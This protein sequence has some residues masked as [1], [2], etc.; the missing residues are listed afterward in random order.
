MSFDPSC[1][2]F[3]ASVDPVSGGRNREL[4]GIRRAEILAAIRRLLVRFEYD[5][6]TVRR[7]AEASGYSVQTLYNLVGPRDQAV[8]DAISQYLSM[9]GQSAIDRA[10][11][12]FAL[13]TFV[14]GLVESM[15]AYPKFTHHTCQIF[16]SKNRAV[17]YD[18]R[19]RQIAD[20]ARLLTEQRRRGVVKADCDIGTTAEQMTFIATG[21]VLQWVERP[22][23]LETMRLKLTDGFEKLLSHQLVRPH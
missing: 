4:Q 13:M 22:F 17:F 20:I 6:V 8:S 16:F 21:L 19:D 1:P 10:G 23:P 5:D 7:I 9:V 12:P 11:D 18:F 2:I 3:D 15:G 14:D